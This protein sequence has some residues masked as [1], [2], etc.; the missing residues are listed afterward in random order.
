[1]S[2]S[3]P[4]ATPANTPQHAVVI[5]G[6]VAGLAT[7][8]LLA[9]DGYRVTLVEQNVE[10]GGRAGS[11]SS[12][13][14]RFDTGPSWYLMP[15][16]FDHFF[17]M[18]G[19]STAAE[20][21]LETLDP[22]YRVIF[23]K[24]HEA[25]DVRAQ[26]AANREL[27][28][29]LEPGSGPAFD[30]Y[31]A[32]AEQTLDLATRSFLYTNFENLS[33][34]SSRAVIARA[35]SLVRLLTRSLHAFAR[36]HFTD[37]RILRI[38]GYPAVFLGSSPFRAPAIYH[39]M[40]GLDLNG[41]VQYPR[42]GFTELVQ[43]LA[44]L[45]DSAGV[46]ILT[47]TRV[48]E[49]TTESAGRKARATGVV[50]ERCGVT[51]R[52]EADI[53]VSAA[54]LHHTETR[55]LPPALQSRPERS[56]KRTVPGPGTVLVFLGIRGEIPELPHHTLLFTEDWE[57]NFRRID[58]P[59]PAPGDPW[60]PDQTSLYV[61]HP[62]ASDASVAPPGHSNLFVL[63][64]APSD[65]ELGGEGDAEV[66]RITDAAID[67]IAAWAKIPDLRE[68]IVV[69]RSIGPRDFERDFNAWRGTALGLAHTTA[70]SAF[71]RGKNV[72]SKVSGLYYAG[73]TTVPGIGLPMC[74][75]SAELVLKR[76][77]GDR[78][79]APLPEP[80]T[81]EAA[82]TAGTTKARRSSEPHGATTVP[83]SAEPTRTRGDRGTA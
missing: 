6:G 67:Q 72:S 60:L 52:I 76:L 56:W 34:F 51:S 82:G 13:G 70:Q 61:C 29:R 74:L 20:L 18:M 19:S 15:E 1:M 36:D 41:G 46:T 8:G 81:T 55:L 21:D 16:V 32:S 22:G 78:G 42:G 62:S 27:F 17:A 58:A 80:A 66:E 73:A 68:R 49:I 83:G 44:R 59:A 50:T 43:A 12:E 30:R 57:G 71:F 26:R 7:A 5:G 65:P 11:W 24:D 25:V 9:R 40:S 45:A 31:L 48:R 33:A 75:I 35:G 69:R 54:D 38:L 4:T 77:R 79:S 3:L 28:E 63:V 2:E 23:E 47:E 37:S 14:F 10:V 39:L 64:P 53:V